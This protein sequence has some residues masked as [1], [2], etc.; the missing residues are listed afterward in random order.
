MKFNP[1]N[2]KHVANIKN[3][4]ALGD[5][6]RVIDVVQKHPMSILIT[7]F[8]TII[9]FAVIL[10]GSGLLAS[11]YFADNT[12]NV[13]VVVS[14]FAIIMGT[15][16]ALVIII[17]TF[18]F[19]NTKIIISSEN[20]V[21]VLQKDLLHNKTSRLALT[22]IEDVTSEQHGLLATIFGYGSLMIETAGEQ[23][24]FIFTFC[25]SPNRVAKQLIDAK[26]KIL[27]GETIYT[28]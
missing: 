2:E 16:A 10:V 5:K 14:F 13:Y 9:G 18:L 4:Y 3:R 6:E 17:A 15:I 19:L 11:Y 20:L 28:E 7:I 27:T 1:N 26:E 22:D 23:A 24:N 25:P 12:K 21:Q 8:F